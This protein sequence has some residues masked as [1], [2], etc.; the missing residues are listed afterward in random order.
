MATGLVATRARVTERVNRV[1]VNLDRSSGYMLSGLNATPTSAS[2]RR[3]RDSSV[4]TL[5]RANYTRDSS[6]TRGG[7]VSAADSSR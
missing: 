4:G 3:A 1:S 7:R 5:G 2:I 6:L